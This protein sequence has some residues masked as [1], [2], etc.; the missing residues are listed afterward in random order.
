MNDVAIPVCLDIANIESV[1]RAQILVQSTLEVLF[2]G[3]TP[4]GRARVA[5]AARRLVAA[6]LELRPIYCLAASTFLA[7]VRR[8][9]VSETAL[10]GEHLVG[11]RFDLNL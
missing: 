2:Y 10:C 9:G 3:K 8:A 1:E 6:C 11:S 5:I 4:F 7:A